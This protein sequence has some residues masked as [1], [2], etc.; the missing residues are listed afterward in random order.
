[1]GCQVQDPRITKVGGLPT[2][3]PECFRTTYVFLS[4]TVIFCSDQCVRTFKETFDMET[5]CKDENMSWVLLF[6]LVATCGPTREGTRN[7]A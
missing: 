5:D 3:E 7:K 2:D 4:S 6:S 1:M